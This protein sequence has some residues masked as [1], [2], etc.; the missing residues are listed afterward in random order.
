MNSQRLDSSA[1]FERL[2]VVQSASVV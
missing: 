2:W 1:S